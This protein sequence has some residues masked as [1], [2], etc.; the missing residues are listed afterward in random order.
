MATDMT[1]RMIAAASHTAHMHCIGYTTSCACNMCVCAPVCVYPRVCSHIPAKATLTSK[2][3]PSKIYVSPPGKESLKSCQSRL[4][5]RHTRRHLRAQGSQC[6]RQERPARLSVWCW[7]AKHMRNIRTS[8]EHQTCTHT[9]AQALERLHGSYTRAVVKAHRL[10][11]KTHE[12]WRALACM[13]RD[14]ETAQAPPTNPHAATHPNV[15]PTCTSV[16][17]STTMAGGHNTFCVCTYCMS[18]WDRVCTRTHTHTYT[19]TRARAVLHQCALVGHATAWAQTHTRIASCCTGTV[20][21]RVCVCVC[22]CACVSVRLTR[23]HMA[24]INA[25]V[26]VAL[27]KHHCSH[28][29]GQ[30]HCSLQH[31]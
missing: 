22:V 10:A 2:A 6:L 29:L 31:R 15:R 14:R 23:H 1:A 12:F 30:E 8:C 17:V 25:T 4:G 24:G 16:L 3:P 9:D 19:H 5:R 7:T 26:P 21:G 11:G 27:L 13:A 20:C 18:S 28:V